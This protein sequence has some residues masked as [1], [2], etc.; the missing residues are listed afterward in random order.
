MNLNDYGIPP[1]AGPAIRGAE[2][3]NGARAGQMTF[4]QLL[5]ELEYPEEIAEALRK[6]VYAADIPQIAG[7]AYA[8]E[9]LDFPLCRC[10]PLER[11][12][13]VTFLLVGKYGEYRDMGITD[14]IIFDTFRDVTLRAEL[15]YRES[16]AVGLSV[17]DVIWFRHIMN[18]AIFKIGVLQFQPFEMVY[19]DEELLGE[20]YMD[21]SKGQKLSLPTGTPVIN[22]HIQRGADLRREAVG[23]SLAR[24]RAFFADHFPDAGYRNFLC[25]S[26]LLYPPMTELLPDSSRIKQFASCFEIIGSCADAEQGL[27]NLRMGP[28]TTFLNQLASRHPDRIGFAC[29]IIRF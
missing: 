23:E 14:E 21:F 28:G 18:R 17:E 24:A 16:G 26:W 8:G 15:Y 4:E 12:S 9:D 22:C 29:G 6:S 20:P 1:S 2:G 19:L 25:Y 3:R 7:T 5:A 13:T 11:L 27:E 10:T